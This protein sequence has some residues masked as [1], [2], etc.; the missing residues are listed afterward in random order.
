MISIDKEKCINCGACA[1]VCPAL[2]FEEVD[3]KA[4]PAHQNSCIKC[5]HCVAVCP[6]DAARCGEFALG[7]FA[8]KSGMKPLAGP[9]AVRN[10]MAVRRSVREFKDKEVSRELLEELAAA[11]AHAPTGHNAQAVN[12][13]VITDRRLIERIDGRILKMFDG[14]V[15]AA[16]TPVAGN[17]MRTVGAGEF[18]E[19]LLTQKEALERFKHAAQPDKRMHVFRG[20]PVLVVA[21]HG[22]EALTGKEDCVIALAQM[23]LLAEAHGLGCTWIGY[24]VAAAMLDP[25]IKKPL[26]VPLKHNLAAAAILG[27][28]RRKYKRIIPRKPLA[29]KWIQ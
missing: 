11:A 4:Y 13:S 3:G 12:L 2:V 7:E 29:I 24:L 19:I 8:L 26:G 18:A 10:L 27:W 17:V 14:I 15:R 22:I 6:A 5:W 25:T 21:H 9:E 16:T 20:A 23:Q 1:D 28:P